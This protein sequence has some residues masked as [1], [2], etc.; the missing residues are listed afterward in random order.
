MGT[1]PPPGA[2][3]P[4]I[5]AHRG[6]AALWPENS[7]TAFRGALALGVDLVECDVHQTRDGEVLV[8]HDPTLERT[9]TGRGAVRDLAW[10]ELATVTVRGT[11]AERVPRL[12]ELLALIGSTRVGLLLE[13]KNDPDNARYAGIEERVLALLGAAGVADRTTVMAFDWAVLERLRALAAPVRLT[14]LLGH[15]QA[16]RLGGVAAAA[17]RVG[18]LGG[19]D[20]GIERTLLA[21]A[22]VRAARDAGLTIGVWTVNDPA[23]VHRALDAGVDYVT[24]DRPDLALRLRGARS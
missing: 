1:A 24:T 5:C 4:A 21:P 7:L 6:G 2:G 16:E 14:G 8:V 11:S 17:A 19:D 9:T 15:R 20:L 13:I 23:D 18:A 12:A 22:A 3:R 10:A